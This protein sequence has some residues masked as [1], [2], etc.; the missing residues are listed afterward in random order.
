MG[1]EIAISVAREETR[2]AVLD[3]GVVTDLF[4]DRAKHKDF[5]GNI[6]KG[7]VAKVLPGMQAAF[8]DI[9]LEKA[10]FMHVSDL[11]LDAE[12]DDTLL[13]A[14]DD[15]KD[16]DE[17][18]P[19]R[20]SSKPIEQLL[21]EGQELM[22]QI[23]K[24]PIGTKGPRVTTYVSLPGRYLVFMPNVEHIGVSRRIARDEERARL[25][26]IMKRVRHPGCGYIVRTVS[27]GV[28]EDEL[29]SD[30][31]FL[32]VLWQDI[33]TKRD[34]QPAPA[35]LHTDLSLSFRVVRD[36]FGKKVE[37]LWIDSRPEY[38]AVRDFVQRFSPEQ[39]SRIHF[40]DKDESLFDYLGVE[41]EM[42][43]ALSRK[44]WLKSG[45]YLV[46]DHTE[47]MT[48]IDVNTGRFVG[49]R[50]Q[51]ETI[52]RN[53]LEAAKEVAYQVKL[54]GIGGIIIVDFIDM[55]REKNRDK[56]YHALVDAMASDKARTRVSRISDLGL[57][58]ISRERVREDLLRSLSEP[59]R[60]CEGRGYTKS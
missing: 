7:K 46:I 25:K 4:G 43:R 32:H 44:V 33:K 22:V 36:L 37:R 3:N 13:D 47:A 52:L 34:Q 30:V 19:R 2:V 51:E 54:R 35:L 41:Q 49:K 40:Y 39:T 56:V 1:V 12:P 8:V 45:G 20:E 29:R 9:G 55:E 10:A 59:C 58:E 23:S 48:V 18:R 6:Y 21:S 28:K 11:S 27:E 24:G 50:D 26:D 17:M 31:D 14:D 5:V 16:G 57:I 15:D 60:Y 38:E 53:N 42:A